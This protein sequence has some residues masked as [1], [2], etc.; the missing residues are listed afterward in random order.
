MQLTPEIV[1]RNVDR[2]DAVEAKVLE[3]IAALER[4]YD[5]IMGCRVMIEEPHRRHTAGN[6]FHI[7]VDLTVPGREI[8]VR[9]DPPADHAHEDVYVAVRD[10]FD[11]VRRQLEDYVRVKGGS[12][13]AHGTPPHGN[14]AR[15]FP[16]QDHGFITTSDGREVYFHRNAVVDARFEDLVEGTDVR[17]VEAQGKEGPQASTVRRVG[18]HH[19]LAP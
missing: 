14:V 2:S 18:H 10:A 1:F 17:F 4:Y 12:T 3:R 6:L 16:A 5:R 7:R 13:K 19:H 8:V 11:A 15:L 9:R